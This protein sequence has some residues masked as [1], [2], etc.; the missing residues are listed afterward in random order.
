MLAAGRR[1]GAETEVPMTVALVSGASRGL[2]AAIAKRLAADGFEVAVNYASSQ[3]G[4]D[5]VVAD[6][7]ANGGKAEAF[8][9]DVTD[10][11]S[12]SAL[13]EEVRETL[14][15]VSVL[16]ANATGP[17]P[18]VPFEDL[19]WQDHLNQLEFFVKSPTLL[20][21]AVLP[22]MRAAGGGRMIQIGS[23]IFERGLPR[24]SAYIA[25]KGAQ[26]GL[27]RSWA[28]ELG[29]DGITVNLVAPGW[30]PVER[31]GELTEE[32]LAGYVSEIPMNRIGKPE[33]V[34]AAVAYLASEG[35][36]FITGQR[37]TVNG[38]H[39]MD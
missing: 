25:A 37:I 8:K 33:D 23:D 32:D 22:D 38:G 14:G 35:S 12:V 3:A 21:Q 28:R 2:G 17:Q 15:P 7:R 29:A 6:I 18:E 19:T 11:A 24:M 34:A 5:K 16:V 31:H 10:E 9:G 39:N 27:T 20:L 36:S 1:W 30:V 26:M 4:A 13:V